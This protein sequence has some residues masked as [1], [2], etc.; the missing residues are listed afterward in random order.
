L[1]EAV[2]DAE[3][4]YAAANL[5]EARKAYA[6]ALQITPGHVATLCKLSRVESE[7]GETQKG[8]TQRLTWSDAVAHAREAVRA[9]PDQAEPHVMLA[10]ALGRQA[11]REGPKTQLALSKEIKA[12]TDLSLKIDP[13][14]GRAWHV[15][16]MWNVKISGLGGIGKMIANSVLGGVPKGASTANADQAFQKAIALEPFYINHRLEYGRFLKDEKRPDDARRELEKAI[17]LPPTSSALD[18]R[19]QAEARELLAKLPKK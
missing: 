18:P 9:A 15:L 12:E 2:A 13:N 4:A 10:V 7:L 6:D 17:A 11:R 8:D 14:I 5:E 16:A 19:F 3:R 1:E